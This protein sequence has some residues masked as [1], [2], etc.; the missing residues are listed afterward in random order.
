MKDNLCIKNGSV[1]IT[2][3]YLLFQ[4]RLSVVKSN[5]IFTHFAYIML[6]LTSEVHAPHK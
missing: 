3:F 2:Y 1:F 4:L 5:E 6:C